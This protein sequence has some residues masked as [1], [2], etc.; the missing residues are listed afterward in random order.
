MTA[1][2]STDVE[3]SSAET[4]MSAQRF[5]DEMLPAIIETRSEAFTQGGEGRISV[6][7]HP[8]G[9]WTLNFGATADRSA[10]VPELDFDADL[11]VTWTESQFIRLLAGERCEDLTP[12]YLGDLKLLGRLGALLQPPARGG[13]GARM[14]GM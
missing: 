8:I 7:V 3:S 5:F 4:P 10:V 14:W 6:V 9:A 1:E 11:V 13:L 2:S 12:L